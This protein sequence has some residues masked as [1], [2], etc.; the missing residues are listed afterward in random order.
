MLTEASR[1]PEGSVARRRVFTR[2]EDDSLGQLVNSGTLNNWAEIAR[3]M[4]GR[5][6]RQ[7]RDRWTNYLAPNITFQPW[8]PEE[9]D[10]ITR[11]VNEIGTKWAAIARLTVGRSGNAVKNRWYSC[12][13]GVCRCNAAGEWV[14]APD[15]QARL[16]VAPQP[17]PEQKASRE[18]EPSGKLLT[19]ELL[20]I[21]DAELAGEWY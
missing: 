19:W 14:I 9:D 2:D 18:E 4:P 12:L 5:T 1:L 13:K 7:C 17:Q 3:Q 6:S 15:L 21:D 8:R 20:A 16:R 10:L 11:M